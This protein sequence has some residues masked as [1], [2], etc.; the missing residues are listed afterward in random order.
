MHK[1]LELVEHREVVAFE[2]MVACDE[3]ACIGMC[4]DIAELA[5]RD[6]SIDRD[7]DAAQGADREVRDNPLGLVAHQDCDHVALSDSKCMQPFCERSDLL[8]Q[9]RIGIP[10][11]AQTHSAGALY[12]AFPPAEA[13]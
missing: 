4:E 7:H 13:R 1:W 11:P 9:R 6:P 12:Q 10:S 3:R 2:K 8:A 5:A